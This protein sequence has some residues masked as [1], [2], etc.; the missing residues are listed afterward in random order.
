M[1]RLSWVVTVSALALAL[2]ACG[3][4]ETSR[5][6]RAAAPAEEPPR[7]LVVLAPLNDSGVTGTVRLLL[8]DGRLS[9]DALVRGAESG[10]AHLQ[11]VH[12][13]DGGKDGRC[14]TPALDRD[15]DGRISLEE[16]LPAYGGPAVN[17][18]PFP[19]PEA[20]EFTYEQALRVPRDLPL[21]RGV[22][23]IHGQDVDGS[24]DETLPIACGAIAPGWT[25]EVTLEPVN[26]SGAAGTARLAVRGD[27]LTAW[28]SVA[29]AQPGREHLQ[30]IHIPPGDQPA[31]CPTPQLDRD[32]DGLVSLE[33]ATPVWGPPRVELKPFPS[34]QGPAFDYVSTL[35]APVPPSETLDR[36]VVAIHGLDVDGTYDP[37][38]PIACG[39]IATTPAGGT[40]P[41]AGRPGTGGEGYE[42][43]EP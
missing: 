29:G 1:R 6:P 17:L 5:P 4:E 26:Q 20:P 14:P 19:E 43:G 15:G 21:D 11:H 2:G 8:E 18:E 41:G 28:I 34:S 33:E 36:G 25:R 31:R 37:L 3:D 42:P 9:V 22:V 32:R 39:R 40:G 7:R 27:R 16:G 23:V 10:R 30:H 35:E 38:L 12:L 24:Y 13:P